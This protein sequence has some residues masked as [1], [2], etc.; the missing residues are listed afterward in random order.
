MLAAMRGCGQNGGMGRRI[1]AVLLCLGWIT[2]AFWLEP[3]WELGAVQWLLVT[4]LAGVCAL[5]L[6]RRDWLPLIP[7]IEQKKQTK[8]KLSIVFADS[9]SAA[10]LK[11]LANH[12]KLKH[13]SWNTH[14]DEAQAAWTAYNDL[15]DLLRHRDTVLSKSVPP[16]SDGRKAESR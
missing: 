8:P 2:F 6:V 10:G 1:A 9:V 12:P 4:A 14:N 7:S 5:Y 11:R 16:T 15:L 13:V 3:M